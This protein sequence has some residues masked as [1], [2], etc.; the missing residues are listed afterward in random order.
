MTLLLRS[1]ATA[2]LAATSPI[3][4]PDNAH[5]W[6]KTKGYILSGEWYSKP[7]LADILFSLAVNAKILTKVKNAIVVVAFLIEDLTEEDFAAS[8]STKIISKIES[9]MTLINSEAD[10]AKNFLSATTTQQAEAMI[11]LQKTTQDFSS[12][13][14]KLTQA[15]NKAPPH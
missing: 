3:T 15:S 4:G 11:A 2:V 12:I 6:I 5:K 13:V 1:E 14:N 8:L 9:A 7:K 10:S